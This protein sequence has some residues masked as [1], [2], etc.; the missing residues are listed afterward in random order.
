MMANTKGEVGIEAWGLGASRWWQA[1]CG[2]TLE[3]CLHIYCSCRFRSQ[4]YMSYRNDN[5]CSPGHVSEYSQ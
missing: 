4:V 3:N 5:T 1:N 2:A